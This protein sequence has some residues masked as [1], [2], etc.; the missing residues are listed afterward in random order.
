MSG[1]EQLGPYTLTWPDGV[2]P[3][4]ADAL[5]LGGF[6]LSFGGLCVL[7]QTRSAIL[8][9]GLTGCRYLRGKLLQGVF[10]ALLLLPLGRL[11]PPRPL[12]TAAT[13]GNHQGLLAATAWIALGYLLLFLVFALRTWKK[14]RKRG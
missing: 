11:F 14:F 10:S 12:E 2:F 6:L 4:G 1:R 7:C 13:A 8:P 3:L 9:A 5:A